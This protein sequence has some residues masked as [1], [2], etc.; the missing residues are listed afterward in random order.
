MTLLSSPLHDAVAATGTRQRSLPGLYLQLTKA[1]LSGLVL[2]TA[3]AGYVMAGAGAGLDWPRLLWT[4]LGTGLAA[5]AAN[6]L[7][8]VVE[9]G[10]D[11][12]MHRTRQRPLPAGALSAAHAFVFSMLA[13]FAGLAILG[14]LVNLL[15]AALAL[16]TI[17]VYILLY[18][19]LKRVTTLNTLVG[20]VCGAIPPMIGWAAAAGRLEPGAWVLAALLFVWQI[21]HFL[22]LAWMYRDDYA[23]ARFAMLPVADSSGRITSQVVVVTSLT[24]IPVALSAT[25]FGL[26]GWVY[27]IVALL[28]GC[29]LAGL[30]ARLYAQRSDANARRLFVA[31]ITYLP[32]LLAIMVADRGP[33]AGLPDSPRAVAS[34]RSP[35]A[36]SLVPPAPPDAASLAGAQ[37]SR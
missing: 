36:T 1:R 8:Q 10:L 7:N 35:A 2:L 11:G 15:S 4:L 5:G 30:G 20:A 3:A 37:G 29:W 28:L 18:T 13:A 26:A 27:A 31:S 6:A 17:L 21:P 23:R 24:L 19:P 34:V 16:V 9:A 22:A 33:P 12:L 14:L 32:A 25:L